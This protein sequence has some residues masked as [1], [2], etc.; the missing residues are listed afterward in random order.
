MPNPPI[1][2]TFST[3]QSSC[4]DKRTRHQAEQ[5]NTT[6]V[7]SAHIDLSALHGQ[8][9]PLAFSEASSAS[10]MLY[11]R[12]EQSRLGAAPAKGLCDMPAFLLGSR[13][14]RAELGTTAQ[15]LLRG[16]LEKSYTL[17]YLDQTLLR[18]HYDLRDE[19]L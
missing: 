1:S 13:Q 8:C 6:S 2:Q 7:Q 14:E 3:S 10:A 18:S 5:G 11:F 16:T 17:L 15:P 12:S 19:H 4:K 9:L